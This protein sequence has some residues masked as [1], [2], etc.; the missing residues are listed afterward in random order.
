ML[1][2]S[3][4]I[5]QCFGNKIPFIKEKAIYEDR[6]AEL[7]E[8][9]KKLSKELQQAIEEAHI[10]EIKYFYA[11]NARTEQKAKL[12]V[13]KGQIHENKN[14]LETARADYQ[15]FINSRQESK[16]G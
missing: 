15:D 2:Q 13:I 5:I 16:K 8:K 14:N 11:K 6:I 3:V 1:V 12:R 7:E 9:D 4:G 10:A